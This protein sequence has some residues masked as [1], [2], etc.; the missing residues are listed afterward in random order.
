MINF[1][2]Q[3]QPIYQLFSVNPETGKETALTGKFGNRILTS[4]R[5]QMS[6]RDWFTSCQVGTDSTLPAITQT[7][8][9]GYVAGTSNIQ[10]DVKGAQ[11]SAP[12]YGWRRKRFRFAAG[13]TAGNLSEVGIGWDTASGDYL[14]TRALIVDIDGN[15]TTV[16][17][18]P[19]EYLDVVV[20]IRYYPPLTDVTG[21]VVLNGVTYDYILR[22]A[23]VT[24]A[25]AWG[26]YI[27]DRIRFY[28]PF[29][30][31]W[32]MFDDDIGTLEQNPNGVAYSAD[33]NNEYNAAY[34]NNS[35]EQAGGMIIGPSGW[36][37]TTGKLGRSL[38][39]LTTAGAYQIQFDSQ[40]NPGFGVPKTDGYNMQIQG[41]LSWAE[42]I[43]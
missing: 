42:K 20:E 25:G 34:S 8:L 12:Y 15:Q 22:A 5:N 6:Q 39:I 16:T 7:A 43:L 38:S 9:L 40:S 33:N 17:P 27:G 10:E 35:F 28:A 13:T 3:I 18:L 31:S 26:E 14:A 2:F 4:G 37:A 29:N 41:R 36:N 11:P 21:T 24:S 23:N 1:G 32:Q 19:N 30:T